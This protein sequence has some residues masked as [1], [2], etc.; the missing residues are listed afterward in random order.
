M[1]RIGF[2]G[3]TGPLGRGLGSRLA[4][5]GHAVVLGSR[6]AARAEE[7]AAGLHGVEG[8]DNAAACAAADV[9]FVTVPY[10]AQARALPALAA[11]LDAKIVVCTVVPL[12]VD[13]RGPHPLTVDEGSGA[14]QCQALL[15]G[16]RVVAGFHW[17]P[18]PKLLRPAVALD[19]DVP[20]CA[21]DADAAAIVA[22]LAGDVKSLRGFLAGPLRLARSLEGLTP[23]LL[24]TN[25]R[26]RAHTGVRFSGLEL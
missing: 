14:E 8:A 1:T 13:E 17:V 7:A 6:D 5:A 21:D 23:L 9:V 22:D 2:I 11:Q 10:E 24:S 4:L 15:P 26:Y 3:G 16:S 20:L 12:A 18:A 19:M 25:K